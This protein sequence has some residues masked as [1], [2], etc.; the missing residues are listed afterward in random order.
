[1]AHKLGA[2]HGPVRPV[3]PT[4]VRRPRRD[5]TGSVRLSSVSLHRIAA[6]F[7][8]FV[9]FS[10]YAGV[11]GLV[12]G[13]LS[14][15]EEIDARLPFDSL[16]FAGLALLLWVAVPMTAASWAAARRVRRADEV[17][18]A[19]GV[20]LVGWIAVELAFIQVY[21]W[22]HPT[23]LALAIITLGLAWAIRR[24]PADAEAPTGLTP[25]LPSSARGPRPTQ[26]R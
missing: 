7:T 10:A 14:F 2:D 17:V 19:A 3:P 1:M 5:W 16:P 25:S 23:Y 6:V 4:L 8:G 21:S 22:F 20:V 15:G 13:G 12:G 11:V 18:E 9:A 26:Q 24:A